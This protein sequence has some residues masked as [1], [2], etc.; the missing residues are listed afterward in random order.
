MPSPWRPRHPG[1]VANAKACEAAVEQSL[2]MATGLNPYVGYEQAAA[3]A[4]EAFRTGKTVRE[5]C[6]EKGVL[7]L[8]ETLYRMTGLAASKLGWSDRGTLA[9]G[10]AADVV[11]FD[12][13]TVHDTATY[14]DPHQYAV[15]ISQVIVN[16]E[17][18]VCDGAH[19]GARPGMVL[20]AGR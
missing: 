18:V 20:G 7:S 5:L 1:R 3:L 12:P 9:E 10:K 14:Q 19:T 4:K 15:G 8:E 17:R 13:E 11:V 2:A 16:G 6:R